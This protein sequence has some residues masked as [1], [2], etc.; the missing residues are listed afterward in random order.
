M[1]MWT[2]VV[3]APER[4]C[5]V[6]RVGKVL[7]DERAWE[8]YRYGDGLAGRSSDR[9]MAGLQDE[10]AEAVIESLALVIILRSLLRRTSC[11]RM[12]AWG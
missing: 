6:A 8:G 4:R 3:I 7:K 10:R 2:A 9:C 11:G 1:T 12:K 5:C